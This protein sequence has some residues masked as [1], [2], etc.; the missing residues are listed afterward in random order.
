MRFKFILAIALI[1]CAF[2]VL[3]V[4]AS[5]TDL[6]ISKTPVEN[7]LG[8][9]PTESTL[10]VRTYQVLQTVNG[11][12]LDECRIYV[13]KDNQPYLNNTELWFSNVPSENYN[14]KMTVIQ[15]VNLPAL[16]SIG[17]KGSYSIVLKCGYD[18]EPNIPPWEF[19]LALWNFNIGEIPINEFDIDIDLHEQTLE[20][21]IINSLEQTFEI[22]SSSNRVVR[23]Y[24]TYSATSCDIEDLQRN[25]VKVK[26]NKN[27]L[28]DSEIYLSGYALNQTTESEFTTYV[29]F[30]FTYIEG[31]Q[32]YIQTYDYQNGNM[33][34]GV[35]MSVY[36]VI[37]NDG[38]LEIGNL[39][40]T[41]SNSES[42][43]ILTLKGNTDYFIENDLIGYYSVKNEN[44]ASLNNRYGYLWN[45]T[46]INPLRLYYSRLQPDAQ[47]NANFIVQD[48][49]N[50][51]I[52]GVSVTMDNSITKIS[53]SIG[54]L[55]FNN[56]SA[57][58]HTFTFIKNG[59]QTAQ[60][61]IDIQ[62]QYAAFTQTLF[63]D[64]QIIQP[65][66]SPSIY[67]TIQP[68][69]S[70]SAQP[71]LSPIDKPSNIME[72]VSFGFAKIFGIKTVENA[73]YIFALMLILF[74]AVVAGGITHQALGFIAGGMIGFVF[75]LAV[76]LV[77]IW[78]FFA[79]C[80]L[81]VIYFVLKGGNEG[82]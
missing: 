54:G 52:A 63:K 64:D 24:L 18:V 6:I 5:Y 60:R 68:T 35:N 61:T 34:S 20:L 65:T 82:F 11:M 29:R 12:D 14:G 17:G 27:F 10:T 43:T 56:V 25:Y 41:N 70:P 77:P 46:L 26:F 9:N 67:P 32:A 36:E 74:P 50:N 76:G 15:S 2:C 39:I 13:Y 81:A 51:G 42:Q 22:G 33:L 31:I 57:G 8:F 3:P 58:S 69:V 73:N 78:V 30:N 44:I 62:L 23:S 38:N 4:N 53:N 59:Y 19:D 1:L 7:N 21:G 55:T 75:A 47:Y 37:E 40:Y 48:V 79:M 66:V 71:T 16:V 28:D 80:L 45:P 72:S 49:N